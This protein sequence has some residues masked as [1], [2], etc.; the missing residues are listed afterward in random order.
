MCRE[1]CQRA[2]GPQLGG[3]CVGVAV[4]ALVL[5]VAAHDEPCL[6]DGLVEVAIFNLELIDEPEWQ[7]VVTVLRLV[8]HLECLHVPQRADLLVLSLRPLFGV[9]PLP[10]LLLRAW[11]WREERCV[12]GKRVGHVAGHGCRSIRGERGSGCIVVDSQFAAA[13][14]MTVADAT[15]VP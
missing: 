7:R 3:W 13:W 15:K 9:W 2:D 8:D 4:L 11:F 14:L 10:C 12:V 1:S 6:V 5:Q